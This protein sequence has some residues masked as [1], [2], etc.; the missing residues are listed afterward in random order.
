MLNSILGKL[1]MIGVDRQTLVGSLPEVLAGLEPHQIAQELP[2]WLERLNDEQLLA[3]FGAAEDELH[4]R[5]AADL[6]AAIGLLG[7]QHG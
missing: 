5:K 6:Q 7:G 3:A 1:A 2:K 4:R